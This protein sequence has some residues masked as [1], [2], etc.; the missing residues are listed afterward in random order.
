[1]SDV[2]G[3]NLPKIDNRELGI[4]EA[5]TLTQRETTVA[6]DLQEL[7]VK[8]MGRCKQ[9]SHKFIGAPFFPVGRRRFGVGF[10]PPKATELL[11]GVAKPTVTVRM[12]GCGHIKNHMAG[13]VTRCAEFNLRALA[14][15]CAHDTYH[16]LTS[17]VGRIELGNT[18]DQFPVFVVHEIVEIPDDVERDPVHDHVLHALSD[19]PR[20]QKQFVG[21]VNLIS[22][23]LGDLPDLW[24]AHVQRLQI[25]FMRV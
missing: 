23:R 15:G 20:C 2:R 11:I 10:S 8:Q 24:R 5:L 13:F 12:H 6:S 9:P 21:A 4:A 7:S 14:V 17:R 22:D 3:V 25:G 1:M 16:D 18:S 19:H